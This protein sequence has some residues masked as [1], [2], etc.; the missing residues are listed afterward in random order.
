MLVMTA[1]LFSAPGCQLADLVPGHQE[2]ELKKRVEADSF[3]RADQ[4]LGATPGN[5]DQ[6]SHG[7]L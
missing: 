5:D 1:T 7:G 3:P 2:A 4:A 6:R